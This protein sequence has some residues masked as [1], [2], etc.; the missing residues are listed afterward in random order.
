MT[1]SSPPS[2]AASAPS[3]RCA[4]IISLRT[5]SRR[6]PA[7]WPCR[8]LT[9]LKLSMSISIKAPGRVAE[10][11]SNKRGAR[12]SRARR[13]YRDVSGSRAASRAMRASRRWRSV[14][15]IDSAIN[16]IAIAP[17]TSEIWMIS[18]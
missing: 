7:R 2:L 17:S 4:R 5:M 15:V 6:S 10:T 12:T 9:P 18:P 11:L 14:P 16:M 1:N 8:S 13:L 3:G